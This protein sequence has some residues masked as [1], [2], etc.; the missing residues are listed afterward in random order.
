MQMKMTGILV[1]LLAIAAAFCR[2]G[3]TNFDAQAAYKAEEW[4]NAAFS[5]DTAGLAQQ[6]QA[7]RNLAI[8]QA[9]RG[10]QANDKN[11][12]RGAIFVKAGDAERAAGELHGL[13]I[14]N[15]EK[16][17]ENWTRAAGEYR[18]LTATDKALKALQNAASAKA[19]AKEACR[20]AAEAFE[21]SADA[22]SEENG[23]RLDQMG[24]V[25]ERAATF[26]ERLAIWP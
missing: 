20:K 18:K 8:A 25:S 17:T 26:R 2:A 23:N 3:E 11:Q 15:Y 12:N 16:A 1:G 10:N 5:R 13:A 9:L 22:Y 6:A 21:L 14:A 19:N 4:K 7:E 24:L